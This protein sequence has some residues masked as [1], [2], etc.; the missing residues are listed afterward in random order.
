[1]TWLKA[2]GIVAFWWLIVGT[3]LAL[4]ADLVFS[5]EGPIALLL[6]SVGLVIGIVQAVRYVRSD[7]EKG[8]VL[9]PSRASSS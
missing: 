4:T 6:L 8:G 9:P 7:G 2:I 1:M 3:A 5:I